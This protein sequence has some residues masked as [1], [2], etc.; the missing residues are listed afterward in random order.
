MYGRYDIN[1]DELRE[2][3]KELLNK[4]DKLNEAKI[5]STSQF[6]ET[7]KKIHKT[8]KKADQLVKVIL[9]F[10]KLFFNKYD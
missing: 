4:I 9:A 5:Y 10:D 1:S 7:R 3:L 8:Y 2:Q 6:F